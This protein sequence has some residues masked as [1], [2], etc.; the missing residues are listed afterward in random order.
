MIRGDGKSNIFQGGCENENIKNKVREYN[1]TIAFFNPPYTRKNKHV[2][3]EF[4]E[5]ALDC[6]EGGGCIAFV[7][8]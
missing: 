6:L 1:P 5:N 2:Q 8:Q 7:N 3:L 4:V